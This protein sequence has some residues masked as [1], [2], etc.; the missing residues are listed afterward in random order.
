MGNNHDRAFCGVPR[1]AALGLSIA[2]LGA[3]CRAKA[4]PGPDQTVEVP[5]EPTTETPSDDVGNVEPEATLVWKRHDVEEQGVSFD[6]MADVEIM[7]GVYESV[8]HVSQVTEPI[9]ILVLHGGDVTLKS[10]REGFGNWRVSDV[11]QVEPLTVC[12]VSAQRQ[13]LF[14]K[15]DWGEGGFVGPDGKIEFRSFS[16]PDMVRVAVAFEWSGVP[17]VVVWTVRSDNREG[18]RHNEEHFFGSIRCTSQTP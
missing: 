1:L 4:V 11:S 17:F 5:A 3:A 9:Q 6:L 16:N 10:W 7:S 8:H 13:T 15:G 18:N 12:G 14:Q 2:I